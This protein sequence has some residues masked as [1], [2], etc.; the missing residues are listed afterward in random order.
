L[1]LPELKKT[2][3]KKTIRTFAFASFLNDLGSDMI[4]PIWPLFVTTILGANMTVLGFIDGM[5]VAIVSISQAV[6]GYLSDYL[7]KR[8]LF[9]WTGYVFGA[10]SRAGY[11][12]S[13]AWPM[14]IPFR[15]LDRMGKIRS[16]PR[17]AIIADISVEQN[18]GKNFGIL[19]AMDN[20]GAVCGILICI[21]LVKLLGYRKLMLIA[22]I[23]SL[24]AAVLIFVK[25]KERKTDQIKIFK[26]ISLKNLSR[27]FKLYLLSSAL[28]ALGSFS[29]SFLLIFAKEFGFQVIFVPVL[30]LIYT[31]IASLFSMPFGALS[32]RTGR[33]FVLVLSFLFWC[34]VC[35]CFILFKT[36]LAIISSFVLYGLHKGALEPVQKTLVSELAPVE[37]RASSLG[38]FQMVIGLCALPASLIAGLM[39]DKIS[40]IVPF[41]Y[42]MVLTVISTIILIFIKTK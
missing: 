21:L 1:T 35:L 7:K 28:F 5:G 3:E 6:S 2:S 11:A 9:I 32:D 19:R 34:L 31:A 42:S 26:G 20:L 23:P 25:I 10:L 29:Y 33:K 17:D 30:Y 41:Y 13:T 39:W 24:I 14:L 37:Y 18:R 36:H 8:K 15:I 12:L 40:L 4:Y 22:V 38:G 16:A 27:D